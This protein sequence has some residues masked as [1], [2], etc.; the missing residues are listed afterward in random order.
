MI[1]NFMT[2]GNHMPATFQ[3]YLQ[4]DERYVSI[5]SLF[6]P[7]ESPVCPILKSI[8]PETENCLSGFSQS[9]KVWDRDNANYHAFVAL[10]KNYDV[11]Y[12]QAQKLD[13]PLLYDIIESIDRII[14]KDAVIIVF[15]NYS[16]ITSNENARRKQMDKQLDYFQHHHQSD[17][18]ILL[19]IGDLFNQLITSDQYGLV[20]DLGKPTIEGSNIIANALYEIVR[21]Y[22]Y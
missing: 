21:P 13:D 11:V 7:D 18:V 14:H 1:G 16:A 4:A 19:P 9:Q 22:I 3:G 10:V 12:L 20:D 5:D 6:A 8:F 15:Q 2:F 17:K